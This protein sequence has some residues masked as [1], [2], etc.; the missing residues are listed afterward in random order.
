M[1]IVAR[2]FGRPR[3]ILGRIV[4]QVMARSNADFNKWFVGEIRG[5]V[6]LDVRRI[7]E[8]GPG[9]GIGLQETLRAFPE[10]RVWGVDLS[11][12]MLAQSRKRNSEEVTSGRLIL[13]QRDAAALEDLAP[14]DLVMAAH[15]V[16]FWH[17]PATELA[18]LH[19]ILRTG[20]L[21]ALGY[22]LRPNMPQVSQKNFPKEGHLLY[23][24]DE[25][26]STLLVAAGFTDVRVVVKGGTDGP[27]G[28][29]ALATA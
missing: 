25:E 27:E 29:I 2:Q 15:V 17:T 8:L 28:R 6:T 5:L 24:S 7:V 3:G 14:V 12:E 10:A 20:G 1:S 13:L 23:D 22:Q 16:Y 4:G 18:E 9:P 21:L 26:L 11:P 19:S